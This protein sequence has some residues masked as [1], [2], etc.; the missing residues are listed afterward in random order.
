MSVAEGIAGGNPGF[1]PLP[2]KSR[3]EKFNIPPDKMAVEPYMGSN[4]NS[5]TYRAGLRGGHIVTAVNGQ[6][7]NVAGRAFLVWFVH[8]FDPGDRITV[9]ALD[10]SGQSRDLTYPLPLRE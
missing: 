5:P 4:T 6:S 8:K 3:R 10:S 1:F 9:T 7:P 2:I